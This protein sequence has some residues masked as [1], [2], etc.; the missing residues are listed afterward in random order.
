MSQ[1]LSPVLAYKKRVWSDI[2][3]KASQYYKGRKNKLDLSYCKS[4]NVSWNPLLPLASNAR[5]FRRTVAMDKFTMNSLETGQCQINDEMHERSEAPKMEIFL[6]DASNTTVVLDLRKM[7]WIHLVNELM[8]W[9]DY[10]RTNNKKEE[11]NSDKF[12]FGNELDRLPFMQARQTNHRAQREINQFIFFDADQPMQ[13]NEFYNDNMNRKNKNTDSYSYSPRMEH[14]YSNERSPIW[15]DDFEFLHRSSAYQGLP[16]FRY[17]YIVYDDHGLLYPDFNQ[18]PK[19]Y[20][21]KIL[22][23]QPHNDILIQYVN[24]H[25]KQTNET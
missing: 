25:L 1:R 3:S 21:D 10:A 19:H 24:K 15:R 9:T 17:D 5:W 2:S 14:T 7:R 13:P 16:H 4:I 8:L 6:K 11:W 20:V 22:E 12:G 18:I 23:A